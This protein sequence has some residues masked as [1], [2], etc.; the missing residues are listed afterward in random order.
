MKNYVVNLRQLFRLTWH[1][2]FLDLR[3][4]YSMIKDGLYRAIYMKPATP[5]TELV[6]C[7]GGDMIP[8]FCRSNVIS[9]H[10]TELVN[11]L[12]SLVLLYSCGIESI[13]LSKTRQNILATCHDIAGSWRENK[14]R[15][16]TWQDMRIRSR[17]LIHYISQYR[18]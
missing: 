4:I 18:V 1:F 2:Q 13:D 5:Y 12:Q 7:S 3:Q 6:N 11:M 8:I 14:Y 10:F 9:T 15:Y 16:I 17:I